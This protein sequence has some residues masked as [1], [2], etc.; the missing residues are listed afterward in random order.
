MKKSEAVNSLNA[1]GEMH[2][3]IEIQNK[4]FNALVDTGSQFN[5]VSQSSY[6][7]VCAPVLSNSTV[8]FSGFGG[9]KVKPIV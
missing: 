2:K 4:K 8:C 7:K 5:I 3:I 1:L 6:N 9:S